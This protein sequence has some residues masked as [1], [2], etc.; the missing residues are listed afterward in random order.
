VSGR[1]PSNWYEMDYSQQ[2]E[3]ED[4]ERRHQRV[5][6]DAEYEA[7][8][9]S[10]EAD[11]SHRRQ[12]RQLREEAAY[13]AESYAEE[14]SNLSRQLGELRWELQHV[15]AFIESK[16]LTAECEAFEQA[17]TEPSAGDEED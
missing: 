17:A 9:A 7:R 8:R 2:R 10:E 11:A 6:D 14:S 12:L 15:R 5:L 16:G 3:W 1:R 13:E 4:N